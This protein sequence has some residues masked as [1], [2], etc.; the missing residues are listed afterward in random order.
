MDLRKLYEIFNW[1]NNKPR[2]KNG[3]TN[4]EVINHFG[5]E[6]KD[7]WTKLKSRKKVMFYEN[8]K[9]YRWQ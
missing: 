4:K 3:V 1:L 2:Y 9:W 6:Y 7:A 8:G 5:I